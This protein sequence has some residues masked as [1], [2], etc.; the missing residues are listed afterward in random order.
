MTHTDTVTARRL[1]AMAKEKSVGW[2]IKAMEDLKFATYGPVGVVPV[3]FSA[4]G[5]VGKEAEKVLKSIVKAK[6]PN[7]GGWEEAR[8]RRDMLAELSIAQLRW[9]S[10][11]R[12]CHTRS[13]LTV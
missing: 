7:G 5:E 4:G 2:D 9:A 13:V 1:R 11:M 10:Y 12:G 6:Y 8:F 3:I